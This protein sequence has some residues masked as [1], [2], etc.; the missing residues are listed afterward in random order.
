MGENRFGVNLHNFSSNTYKRKN[1]INK[2]KEV[3]MNQISSI[4]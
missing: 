4:N 1:K 2:E 3:K